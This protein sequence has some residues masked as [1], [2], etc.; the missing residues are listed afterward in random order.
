MPEL[1]EVETIRR[2]LQQVLPG[3][4]L[5]SIDVHYSGSVKTPS[6]AELTAQLPGRQVSKAGR[7]G[8]YL[9]LYLDDKSVI[10]IHLRMTGKL[11]FSPTA[12]QPD[13]HTHVIF[14]FT[15]G[16]SL[17][18]H[19]VRKF[20]TIY[21]LAQERLCEIK[22]LACLGPEPL[23]ENFCVEYMAGKLAKRKGNIKAL[24]LN[25]EFVAGLGNIY[26]DESLHRA[27]I[28]PDRTAASLTSEEIKVLYQA[29]CEVLNEAIRWRGTTMSDYRDASGGYGQFQERLRVYHRSGQACLQCGT[30]IERIVVAGRGTHF[31][32]N[33]QN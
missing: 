27:G 26:A 11:I 16:S 17:A 1:P 13:K 4:V 8:K 33:C 23:G 6:V 25:Q 29:V 19:D 24:L 20:G 5:A 3:R 28:R 14:N 9:H 18:F 7:R 30:P 31:C 12:L 32:P 2:G 21:W 15:D 10:I 22:G